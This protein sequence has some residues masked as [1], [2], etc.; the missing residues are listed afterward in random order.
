MQ[1][2]FVDIDHLHIC[3]REGGDGKVVLLLHGWGIDSS[4]YMNICEMLESRYRVIIPDFPGFGHSDAP[5]E[6]WGVSEYRKFILKFLDALKIDRVHIVA[7]S[8]GARVAI[9][10]ACQ[11]AERIDKLVMTGA[12]GIKPKNSLKKTVF[13]ILA[14]AGNALLT[15]PILSGIKTRAR[16]LLYKFAGERD[17][18]EAKGIMK[19]ILAH[20]VSEDLTPYLRDIRPQTLLLWGRN[21]TFTPL[22][23]GEKMKNR[24]PNVTLK[25]YED[26]GHR[27]PYERPEDVAHDIIQFLL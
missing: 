23:Q 15:L 24:I 13:M 16:A 27:L 1:K 6:V 17:Y 19:K 22:S 14:K 2:S 10:M 7:H 25:I 8:F 4:R 11:D 3:Y 12:A 5:S 21:D 18:L 9:K 20:V 26:V